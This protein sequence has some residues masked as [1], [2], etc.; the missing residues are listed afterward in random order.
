MSKEQNIITQE[1]IDRLEELSKKQRV[2]FDFALGE[3]K[4]V[5][6]DPGTVYAEDTL[7]YPLLLNNKSIGVV[8][9]SIPRTNRDEKPRATKNRK[10]D[11][12]EEVGEIEE[13]PIVPRTTPFETD[14]SKIEP[15]TEYV[16]WVNLESNSER[17]DSLGIDYDTPSEALR[18]ARYRI[19]DI[20][21]N[22]KSYL[23]RK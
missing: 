11:E 4:V 6:R 10:L 18:I 8:W 9:G 16:V 20:Y 2:K 23:T 22:L 14:T 5:R 12:G 19:M 13:Q 1:E 21:F 15:P 17:T 7:D 3:P